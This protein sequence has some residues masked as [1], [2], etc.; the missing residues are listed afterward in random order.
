MI[1]ALAMIGTGVSFAASIW[2]TKQ[3]AARETIKAAA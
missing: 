2:A 1:T 3:I